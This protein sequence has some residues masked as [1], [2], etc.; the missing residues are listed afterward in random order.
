MEFYVSE[1]QQ[2]QNSPQ[3]HS[4][5]SLLLSPQTQRLKHHPLLTLQSPYV[6]RGRQF[7]ASSLTRQSRQVSPQTHSGSRQNPGP[8]RCGTEA[9]GSRPP[10]PS[11]QSQVPRATPCFCSRPC[12][13]PPS[14]PQQGGLPSRLTSP[15]FLQGLSSSCDFGV[16][17]Q[18]SR[19]TSL[20]VSQLSW[21]LC[22]T[23]FT[24]AL[25]LRLMG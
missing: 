3:R 6:G 11:S 12:V 1:I 9:P 24:A 14:Q 10:A 18:R 20:P 15:A 8:C 16:R 5:H 25:D 21:N 13:H 23:P 7:C 4:F 2:Q 22:V 17:P 19:L